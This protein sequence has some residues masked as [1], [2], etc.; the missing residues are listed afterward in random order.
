VVADRLKLPLQKVLEMPVSHFNLW[1]AY[2]K[3]EQNDYNNQKT[4]AKIRK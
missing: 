2:L 4:T 1:V 3:K